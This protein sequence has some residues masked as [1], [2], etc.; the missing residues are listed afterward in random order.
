VEQAG[1]GVPRVESLLLQ[2]VTEL[3]DPEDECSPVLQNMNNSLPVDI[4]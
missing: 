1:S 2:E 3:L 4:L